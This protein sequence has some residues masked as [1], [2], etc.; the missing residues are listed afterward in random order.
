M[1]FFTAIKTCL[2]KY[3]DVASRAGRSEFWYFVLFLILLNFV[4]QLAPSI[5]SIGSQK[6]N[7]SLSIGVQFGWGSAYSWFVNAYSTF[8]FVPLMSVLA[9]RFND[10]GY[11]PVL[12]WAVPFFLFSA[13]SALSKLTSDNIPYYIFFA[14]IA[15]YVIGVLFVTTRPS[16]P[17]Q[18][19]S[20]S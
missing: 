4:A 19:S 11:S 13:L 9:R 15:T 17:N 6:I 12:I 20:E 16:I 8:V 5:G 7:L 1:T 2:N 3:F 10:A 18:L 14:F